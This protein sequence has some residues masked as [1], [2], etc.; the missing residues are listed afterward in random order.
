M[1]IFDVYFFYQQGMHRLS[2]IT[3]EDLERQY[4]EDNSVEVKFTAG[5]QAYQV[6]LQGIAM[7][8]ETTEQRHLQL[9]SRGVYNYLSYPV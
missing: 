8:A 5:N 2:N 9:S 1:L 4:L 3:S 7:Q 6:S